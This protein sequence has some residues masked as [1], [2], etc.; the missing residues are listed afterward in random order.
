ML[1]F[2]HADMKL[3]WSLRPLDPDGGLAQVLLYAVISAHGSDDHR[4]GEF[5]ITS[6]T[7]PVNGRN[8]SLEFRDAGEP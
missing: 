1:C 8:N 6:H 2:E 5:C 7:F 4:C 3:V